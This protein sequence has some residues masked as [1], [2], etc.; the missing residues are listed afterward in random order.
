[1]IEPIP[2]LAAAAAHPVLGT[3]VVVCS[4]GLIIGGA[5]LIGAERRPFGILAVAAGA[6]TLSLFGLTE[7]FPLGVT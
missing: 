3:I 5:T 4:I 1:M 6:V 7:P 2:A